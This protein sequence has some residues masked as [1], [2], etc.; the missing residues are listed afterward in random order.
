MAEYLTDC[1]Y[2][3]ICVCVCVCVSLLDLSLQVSL[4]AVDVSGVYGKVTDVF[5]IGSGCS[6]V[7]Q[8]QSLVREPEACVLVLA[9]LFHIIFSK[10]HAVPGLRF[11]QLK[12][13][14]QPKLLSPFHTQRN[15]F[16]GISA[17]GY[18][19]SVCL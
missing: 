18:E 9:L 13:K 1:V 7:Q 17:E 16:T 2:V 3:S 6:A 14:K 10:L 11:P 12:N 15:F 19:I 8:T 5:T 4:P